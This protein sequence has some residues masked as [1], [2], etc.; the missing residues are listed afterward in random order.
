VD[1]QFALIDDRYLVFTISGEN[2]D[3]GL[4]VHGPVR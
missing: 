4:W 3:A 1:P 2:R